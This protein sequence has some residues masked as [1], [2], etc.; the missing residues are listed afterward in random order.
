VHSHEVNHKLTA[1][2][3]TDTGFVGSTGNSNGSLPAASGIFPTE[4]NFLGWN[5]DGMGGADFYNAFASKSGTAFYWRA[6]DG[7]GWAQPMSLSRTGD[8]TVHS[9]LPAN[10]FTGTKTAGSCV[11]T[12]TNGIITNVTGC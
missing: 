8:L 11:F 5:A 7:K 10:G 12:I 4:G 1:G 2:T 9:V 6:F 3:A